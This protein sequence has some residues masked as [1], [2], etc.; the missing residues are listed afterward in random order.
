MDSNGLNFWMLSTAADWLPPGGSDSLYFCPD[1][2]RLRL[3]SRRTGDPPVEDF[4]AA[5]A[6]VETAPMTRD[7][8]GTYARWD[9][10]SSKVLAGGV[11]DGELAIYTPP[12][13]NVVTDLAMGFDGV[14]YIAVSDKLLLVDRRKR[15]PDFTLTVPDFHFWRLV[16]LPQGGVLALD[17]TKAAPQLAK[18]AGL[19]PQVEPSDPP[20]P[21]ILRSCQANSDGPAIV[22]RYTL[23]ASETWIAMTAMAGDQ[24][25]LVS[26]A[27]DAASNKN[28]FLR[29]FT[30]SSG[31][32]IPWTLSDT[33]FPYS[34]SWIA[35]QQLAVLA[36]GTNEA[37]VYDLRGSPGKLVS[38]GDTYI[39]AGK[40]AGP[41]AHTLNNPPYYAIG[42]TLY[43]FLPLSLNSLAPTGAT[44]PFAPKIIDSGSGQTTWHRLFM[45]AILPAQTGI[46]V[47]LAASNRPSDFAAAST[48]WYP[49]TFGDV[50][51]GLVPKETPHGVWISTDS[52][53]AFAKP[54]LDGDTE[55]DRRGLFSVL[56]QRVGRA[57]RKLD[58]RYLAI[59]VQLFG[60]RR[61]T[62]E[63]AGV[64]V[65][66]SRFSYVENYLPELYR[67]NLFGPD[68]D[69]LKP[70]TP[71]SFLER[72]VNIF[73]SQMT[74]IEDRIANA[75]LL[76][77]PESAPDS[78]LQWLGGWIGVDTT[79]YPPDRRRDLMKRA[80]ELHR[81]RGTAAGIS[82]AID[83][84]TNGLAST[85]AVLV[86]EAFRL[87]HT[88]ATIL[89]ADLA[90]TDDPLLPGYSGNANSF[91]GDTLFLGD[92]N[93]P[94]FLT[95]FART[96]ALPQEQAQV[97]AFL[98]SLA[99]RMLVFVHTQVPRA[100]LNLI[101]QIVE[102]EKP[103]HV[104]ASIQSASQP[105]LIGIASLVGANTFLTSVPLPKPVVV[106]TSIVGRYDIVQRAP[107]LDPRWENGESNA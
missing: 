78:A 41:F 73:E 57:V 40:N 38:V 97:Q 67:E 72:F 51:P 92:P 31:L 49:H 102:A 91:V 54:M 39:L 101:T 56:V 18:V 90:I 96:V 22:A 16:A 81:K 86:V 68:A 61:T 34:V 48:P 75:Y 105:F 99:W 74:R 46:L 47:W 43:P 29:L 35:D 17:R 62:P 70:S 107:A 30:E 1:K 55:R 26:W 53:V 88:F 95:E 9:A 27:A 24:F 15:W 98:E 66:A 52:E 63:I 25:A 100:D 69:A 77:R 2:Q 64:R 65:Y 106:N 23:P 4:A 50:D 89:G 7:S 85:G 28:S 11:T 58:G 83:I 6:L 84:A 36:T 94:D 71:P 12:S 33:V 59:R 37:L 104:V 87:R 76:M 103:A 19:P 8:F 10:A 44:D 82:L 60:D 45:E 3:R 42:K 5:S 80:S 79:A 21:G 93:N 32:T 14:L 20:N 13:G